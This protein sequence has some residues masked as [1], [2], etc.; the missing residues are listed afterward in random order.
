MFYFTAKFCEI[1]VNSTNLFSFLE[2]SHSFRTDELGNAD[3]KFTFSLVVG[4]SK[5]LK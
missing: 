1:C 5:L 4:K 3:V 2:I